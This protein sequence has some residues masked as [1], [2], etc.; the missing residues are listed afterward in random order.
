MATKSSVGERIASSA[1]VY[2]TVGS[3]L[4][5]WSGLWLVYLMNHPP[6]GDASYYFSA[7]LLLTGLALLAV[8]GLSG[9]LGRSARQADMN[10][11]A[12]G[13]PAPPAPGTPIY[14]AAPPA[15]TFPVRESAPSAG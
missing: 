6:K 9:P 8:A 1:V 3:L 15:E 5:I 13:V 4:I 12:L 2:A 7:G 10:P 11:D 14:A